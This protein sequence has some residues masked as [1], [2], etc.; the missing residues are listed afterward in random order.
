MP[1]E[2]GH[3]QFELKVFSMIEYGCYFL[4]VVIFVLILVGVRLGIEDGDG[5]QHLVTT[6]NAILFLFFFYVLLSASLSVV[7]DGFAF[8]WAPYYSGANNALP[9]LGIA[10]FALVSYLFVYNFVANTAGNSSGMFQS[11][12]PRS[13]VTSL[14]VLL[15]LVGIGLK[16]YVIRQRGGLEESVTRMSGGLAEAYGMAASD[17]SVGQLVNLSGMA[18]VA[19]CWLLIQAIRRRR[20]RVLWGTMFLIVLGLSY[21]ILPK[22]SILI[23]PI[24]TVIIAVSFYVYKIRISMLPIAAIGIFVFGM[25][26]LFIR[27]ILPASF[28]NVDIYFAE[29]PWAHGSIIGFY[30]YSLEFSTFEAM[31]V[32][33]NNADTLVKIFGGTLSA[34]YTTN[35]EPLL[36]IVPRAFWPGKPKE[37]YDFSQ[38]LAT[39]IA[40]SPLNQQT[41][42]IASTYIG[43][44]WVLGGMFGLTAFSALIAWVAAINDLFFMRSLSRNKDIVIILYS[45]GIFTAFQLMRQG[46]LGYVFMM[47]VPSQAGYLLGFWLLYLTSVPECEAVPGS[48]LGK[49]RADLS[50]PSVQDR[51]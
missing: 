48:I 19:S 8:T 2:F 46:G 38:G 35:I 10:T 31:T 16:L 45:I 50:Y 33:I 9:I 27:V 1:R 25:W 22:R 42:G 24:L 5:C 51:L 20:L 17:T 3:F 26:S 23:E 28:N 47:I 14:A 11:R 37:F 21:F 32:A 30:V 34:F 6:H 44:S 29:V 18:E 15:T 36:Y 49:Q 39:L 4:L 43:T 7:F 12:E 41:A 40:G 13:I